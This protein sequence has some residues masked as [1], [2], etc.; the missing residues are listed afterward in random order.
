MNLN[1]LNIEA[2]AA[3]ARYGILTDTWQ[4]LFSRELNA[5][6]FGVEPQMIRMVGEAY[7][8][9]EQFLADEREMAAD[10]F[11]A[12]ALEALGRVKS[13]LSVTAQT[14]LSDAALTHLGEAEAYLIDELIAQIHRDIAMMR[15]KLR[16]VVLA[17]DMS[18]RVRSISQRQALIEHR[19]TNNDNLTFT[20]HDRHRRTWISKKFVRALWRRAL[21]DVYNEVVMLS[22]VDFGESFAIVR[23]GDS[24][25]EQINLAGDIRYFT[26]ADIRD[27][28]FHP[29]SM[30][31]L[32]SVP[33]HVPA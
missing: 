26:Y 1:Q 17:V 31:F 22:L 21:L 7:R 24:Y 9:A 29:G 20:F 13:D 16:Q 6:D 14:K 19:I 30:S 25:G 32:T 3:A 4:G 10:R 27:E 2:D 18:A 8:L 28:V 12:A 33:R 5:S 15:Q 23:R 11:E